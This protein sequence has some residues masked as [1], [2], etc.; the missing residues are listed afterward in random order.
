[1]T[2]SFVFKYKYADYLKARPAF[3]CFKLSLIYIPKFL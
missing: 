3:K 2:I 1:M